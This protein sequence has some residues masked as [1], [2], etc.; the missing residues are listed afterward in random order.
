LRG[1]QRCGNPDSV[2]RARHG[3][4]LVELIVVIVILGILAAIAVPALTGY[5]AKSEDKQWEM[6]ARDINTAAH[7]VLDESYAK[8]ELSLDDVTDASAYE[9]STSGSKVFYLSSLSWEAAS[10]SDAFAQR[11]SHLLGEEFPEYYDANSWNLIFLCPSGTTALATDGFIWVCYPEGR[12][13][14]SPFIVVTYKM[15]HVQLAADTEN[16]FWYTSIYATPPTFTYDPNAGYE[17][18]HLVADRDY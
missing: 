6:R 5:I 18:Y 17:V 9:T 4:T 2:A 7:A 14:G 1:A 10:N 15:S 3:F 11:A 8:G 13:Y 16:T 12:V